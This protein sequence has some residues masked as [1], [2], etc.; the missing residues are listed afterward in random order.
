MRFAVTFPEQTFEVDAADP[1][2]AACAAAYELARQCE[3]GT[4]A[5][6]VREHPAQITD[7]AA[8]EA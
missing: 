8:L 1:Q 3:Q 7:G 4:L 6:A 5:R 2:E